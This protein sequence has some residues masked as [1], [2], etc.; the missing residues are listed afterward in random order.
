MSFMYVTT[1]PVPVVRHQ[2]RLSRPDGHERFV[3]NV[4]ASAP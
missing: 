3:G 4:R 1:M 2:P